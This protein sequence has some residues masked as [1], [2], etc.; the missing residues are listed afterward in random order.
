VV[1]D[2]RVEGIA[3][4]D[5]DR[6]WIDG[7]DTVEEGR[8]VCKVYGVFPKIIIVLSS[9]KAKRKLEFREN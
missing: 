5:Y 7:D 4:L 1:R 8:G 6:Q 9:S 3:M 2:G